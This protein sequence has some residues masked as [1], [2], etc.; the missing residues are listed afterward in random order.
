MSISYL[1]RGVLSWKLSCKLPW[2]FTNLWQTDSLW[3]LPKILH[4]RKWP[5]RLKV[6]GP[7]S[8]SLVLPL[9]L[10]V[11]RHANCAQNKRFQAQTDLKSC[12]F[13]I[14]IILTPN[15]KWNFCVKSYS[16]VSCAWRF[17]SFV[18]VR[19]CVMQLRCNGSEIATFQMMRHHA[20]AVRAE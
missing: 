6:P 9:W 20:R 12:I 17:Y 3:A 8:G 14:G 4:H 11:S 5:L 18:S 10:L 16:L 19:K 15:P 2:H 1:R 7:T 13:S